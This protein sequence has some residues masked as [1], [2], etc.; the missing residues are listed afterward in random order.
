MVQV[1]HVTVNILLFLFM[2]GLT[3]MGVALLLTIAIN[4]GVKD[5]LN[6]V[7]LI[8][9]FCLRSLVDVKSLAKR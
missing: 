8:V 1:T 5:M 9:T 3:L 7:M 6:L 4:L 2:L